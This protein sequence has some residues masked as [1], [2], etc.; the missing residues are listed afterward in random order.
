MEIWEGFA[1]GVGIGEVEDA[2]LSHT[3]PSKNNM[4]QMWLSDFCLLWPGVTCRGIQRNQVADLNMTKVILLFFP[5]TVS[6]DEPLL[7]GKS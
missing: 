7:G 5:L 3:N 4:I 2:S 6:S 1:A